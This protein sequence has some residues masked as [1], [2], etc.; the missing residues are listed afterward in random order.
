MVLKNNKSEK[1]S[2]K[3]YI[4]SLILSVLLTFLFYFVYLM[5]NFNAYV[6]MLFFVLIFSITINV[7]HVIFI[8]KNK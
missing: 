8:K 5:R 2:Y 1:F 7:L 3:T 6:L 4:I